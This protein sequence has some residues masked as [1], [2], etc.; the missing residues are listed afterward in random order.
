[1]L[2]QKPRAAWSGHF[3]LLSIQDKGDLV[4]CVIVVGG[5][6]T[7][8]EIVFAIWQKVPEKPD[9]HEQTLWP[10]LLVEHDPPL[11]HVFNWQELVGVW[12]LLPLK[13]DGQ[14]HDT[15]PK[16]LTEH[17]PP[18]WHGFGWQ[19][20][21]TKVVVERVVLKIFEVEVI[22]AVL[23]IRFF[24]VDIGVEKNVV[25]WEVRIVVVLVVFTITLLPL[26][27]QIWILIILIWT[28]LFYLNIIK[29]IT[30]KVFTNLNLA[31]INCIYFFSRWRRSSVTTNLL[32]EA[33][34]FRRLKKIGIY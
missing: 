6:V 3:W 20:L 2:S 31:S 18:F 16:N 7:T 1:M 15:W 10:E 33:I 26:K 30:I 11:R 24:V 17:D 22:A 9:G 4:N 23:G 32:V 13:P 8:V 25:V 28:N 27:N 21:F 34:Y 5:I 19:A 29:N 14:E 12:Q